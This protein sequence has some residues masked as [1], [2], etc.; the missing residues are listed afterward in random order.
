VIRQ[1]M[2]LVRRVAHARR[3]MA[4]ILRPFAAN[5][6]TLIG[7]GVCPVIFVSG[8]SVLERLTSGY[9]P[10]REAVSSLVFG[11]FG[12][13]QTAMFYLT[14]ASLIALA[15][16]LYLRIRP[17]FKVGFLVLGLLGIAFALVGINRPAEPGT[18]ATVSTTIHVGSSIFIAAAFPI[19][20]LLLGPIMR[21]R[22]HTFLRWYT[23]VAGVSSLLFFLVGGAILVLHLSFMGLFERIMLLNGQMW[24]EVVCIQLLL[25]KYRPGNSSRSLAT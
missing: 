21:S 9:D 10:I 22:G 7:V 14:G 2:T 8:S 16:V 19:A 6:A 15:V 3:P 17:K 1:L 4:A 11:P 25:D 13:V 23:I 12:W 24:V 18:A 5:G 20:C